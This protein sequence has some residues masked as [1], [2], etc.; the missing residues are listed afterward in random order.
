MTCRPASVAALAVVLAV[1][2]AGCAG[3]DTGA[4]ATPGATV[5]AG[6]TSSI[7]PPTEPHGDVGS[8][9]DAAE[10]AAGALAGASSAACDVSR[11]VLETA[12]EMYLMLNGAPPPN[13]LALVEEGLIE[14][15]STLLEVTADGAVV[16]APASPCP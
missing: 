5:T 12:S 6:P 8:L 14:R 13:Q 10:V 11:R 3:S 2:A 7:A 9:S 15:V 16:P 1:L 4:E